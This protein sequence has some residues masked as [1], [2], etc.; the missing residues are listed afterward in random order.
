MNIKEGKTNPDLFLLLLQ[1][2]V[3]SFIENNITI[4]EQYKNKG[5]N[6]IV[7]DFYTGS[8]GNIS[9]NQINIK[10]VGKSTSLI[11]FCI[12]KDGSYRNNQLTDEDFE[13]VINLVDIMIDK[14]LR[15][16]VYYDLFSIPNK[17]TIKEQLNEAV[18]SEN[19]ELAKQ[20]IDKIKEL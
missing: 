18:E 5:Y 11:M 14:S 15:L 3:R 13:M 9:L 20:L 2:D 19:Y 8:S 4:P 6:K 10:L 7:V 1:R 16:K 17:K 12:E